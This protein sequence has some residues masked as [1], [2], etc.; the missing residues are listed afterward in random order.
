[1]TQMTR[2]LLIHPLLKKK[3]FFFS[4]FF[5][6]SV[7]IFFLYCN[8][9]KNMIKFFVLFVFLFNFFF[10]YNTKIISSRDIFKNDKFNISL[11]R[12]KKYISY[13]L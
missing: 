11:I 3:T 5:I 2:S 8:T 12:N 13:I 7:K 1:M 9:L 6:Y 10:I 4:S